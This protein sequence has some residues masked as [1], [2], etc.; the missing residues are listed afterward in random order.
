MSC[1]VFSSSMLVVSAMATLKPPSVEARLH[2]RCEP[3][4]RP[5]PWSLETTSPS[6]VARSLVSMLSS[7]SLEPSLTPP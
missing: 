3:S 2:E 4:S 6:T 5:S 1:E 7:A